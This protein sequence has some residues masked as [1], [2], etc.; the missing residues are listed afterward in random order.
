MRG[1]SI[2]SR[3]LLSSHSCSSG[4]VYHKGN[5]VLSDIDGGKRGK[6]RIE[7]EGDAFPGERCVGLLFVLLFFCYQ[8]WVL[9]LFEYH[10]R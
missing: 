5:P 6:D 4:L 9:V 1:R 8:S 3:F 7:S 2:L 10:G